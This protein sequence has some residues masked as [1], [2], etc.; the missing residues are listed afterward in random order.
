MPLTALQP[1]E[2]TTSCLLYGMVWVVW[3][4]R[5]FQ[6]LGPQST[7]CTKH[8]LSA[9][10]LLRTSKIEA[11]NHNTSACI[12]T[13]D[14][15]NTDGIHNPAPC[16]VMDWPHDLVFN[17]SLESIMQDLKTWQGR[18]EVICAQQLK[19]SVLCNVFSS[20][21]AYFAVQSLK[22]WWQVSAGSQQCLTAKPSLELW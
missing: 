19:S 17:R 8:W 6:L 3:R 1:P 2:V 7:A 15:P 10:L 4:E 12:K 13:R 21:L 5:I 18:A 20:V 22:V 9:L 16:S 14:Q 11:D